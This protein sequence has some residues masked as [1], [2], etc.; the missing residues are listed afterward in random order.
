MNKGQVAAI[1]DEIGTLL[2]LQGENPFRCQAYHNAARAI[3]QLEGS[4]AEVIAAGKL[5]TIR[6][7]GETL[8][9][10]I[11][12][13]ASTGSLPFYDELRQK[14]PAGL[15]EILRLP[16]WDRKKPR[17]SMSS[18]ASTHWRNSGLHVK[19]AAWRLSRDSARKTQQKILEGLQFLDQIG[20]RMRL[21]QA[22]TLAMAVLGPT[23]AELAG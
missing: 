6:G 21:D 19:M 9:D 23:S 1:L 18:L 4:L 14:I 5:G 20:E 2:E 12:T 3:E 16:A 15:L 13:L 10:K 8:R 7:I 11:T 22:H 17:S